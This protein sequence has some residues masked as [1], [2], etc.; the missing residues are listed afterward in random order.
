MIYREAENPEGAWWYLKWYNVSGLMI[1]E[2][3]NYV[4]NEITYMPR[5]L[6]NTYAR[7]RV[8]DIYYDYLDPETKENIKKRDDMIANLKLTYTYDV[9]A[10]WFNWAIGSTYGMGVASLL[11]EDAR[12]QDIGAKLR[13]CQENADTNRDGWYTT[14][15]AEGWEFPPDFPWGI[16]PQINP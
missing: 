16:P 5:Y 8:A 10:W 9:T 3:Y 15:E 2:N 12:T 4:K 11:E 13:S 14:K 6:T 1:S 7:T